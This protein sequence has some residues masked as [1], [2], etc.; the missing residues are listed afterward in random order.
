MFFKAI[1]NQIS[2]YKR[3]NRFHG[4]FWILV[5]F[6]SFSVDAI[7]IE[8][9][10]PL[11]DGAQLACG[12]GKAGDPRSLEGNLYWG[13]A[14]GVE[15]FF[16]KASGYQIVDRKEGKPGSSILRQIRVE[17]IPQKGERNVSILFHAYAGDKIDDALVDFLNATTGKNNSDLLVW[18]GHDRL[19]DRL[20]PNLKNSSRSSKSVAVLACKSE[21]YFGPVLHSIGA[22]QIAMTRTFMAPE[23]YLLEA[24]ASTAAKSGL[25]NK[26]AIRF[27]LV[28][29]YAKYQR[30]SEK[31]AGTVFSNLD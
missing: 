17:R 24:L 13:A 6:I 20:P 18:A 16:K 9:F 2:R 28:K 27:S 29:A 19:M 8:V 25:K 10:V 7:Q 21:T 1:Q 23:A 14:F 30:I 12:K 31:A 4:S 15:S 11:C 5:F 26:K 3:S 22:N